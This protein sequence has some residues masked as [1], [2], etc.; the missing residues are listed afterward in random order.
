MMNRIDPSWRKYQNLTL[1]KNVS[2]EA[3]ERHLEEC[4]EIMLK[5]NQILLEPDKKNHNL[6]LILKGELAVHLEPLPSDPILTLNIGDCVGELSILSQVAVSAFVTAKMSCFLL[7]IEQETLWSMVNSSHAL[8]RNL[9]HI[10]AQKVIE[11]NSRLIE[12]RKSQLEFERYASLDALTGLYNRRWLNKTLPRHIERAKNSLKPLS[13]LMIDVDFF[14]KLNDRYG[15]L[16][17]DAALMHL[18]DAFNRFLRPFDQICRFGGEEF[19]AILNNITGK[20]AYNIAE[21]VRSDIETMEIEYE[22]K[23]LNMTVSIGITSLEAGQYMD[24]LLKKADSALYKAK[25]QGRNCSV[26]G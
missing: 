11:D 15:H 20:E 13:L 14:K 9:L 16:A 1:F 23:I 19:I 17:G 10:L 6:Y 4:D 25:E 18:A 21:R 3:L 12:Q 2:I 7:R 5:K 8:A 22:N 26:V 24:G